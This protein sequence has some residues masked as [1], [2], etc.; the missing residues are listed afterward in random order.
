MKVVFTKKKM[1]SKSPY[2]RSY[3]I[4]D[5]KKKKKEEKRREEKREKKRKKNSCS[6]KKKKIQNK[7]SCPYYIGHLLAHYFGYCW[8][9]Y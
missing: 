9:N 2:H 7:P 6:L 5:K 8:F 3:I 4:S 1:F